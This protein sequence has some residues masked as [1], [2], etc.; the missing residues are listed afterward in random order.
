MYIL[1]MI[2][3]LLLISLEISMTAEAG[4]AYGQVY[5]ILKKTWIISK[6]KAKI[7]FTL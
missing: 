6:C 5:L 1:L 3:S 7:M 2:E 4:D